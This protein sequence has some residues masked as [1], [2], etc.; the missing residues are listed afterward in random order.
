M[1]QTIIAVVV[2]GAL[3]SFLFSTLIRAKSRGPAVSDEEM[4][5]RVGVQL[6]KNSL[7]AMEDLVRALQT[8]ADDKDSPNAKN[9]KDT[10]TLFAADPNRVYREVFYLA[11]YFMRYSLGAEQ[12]WA[13]REKQVLD[14]VI[15]Y[16]KRFEAAPKQG[17][18]SDSMKPT[19]WMLA[20]EHDNRTRA[21][22][23]ALELK[24]SQ[25]SDMFFNLAKVTVAEVTK[26]P[27]IRAV[28]EV[29]LAPNMVAWVEANR[30]V[31]A[32]GKPQTR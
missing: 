29:M 17:N 24:T 30:A 4:G 23:E 6:M 32:E 1:N 28:V 7:H 14:N 20:P 18:P 16:L 19:E 26:D 10:L 25:T 15:V 11:V 3:A 21:F 22:N 8:V 13:V 12:A 31:L 27:K 9:A 5:E 2:G